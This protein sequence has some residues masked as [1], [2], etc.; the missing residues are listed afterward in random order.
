[1]KMK[2]MNYYYSQEKDYQHESPKE[3]RNQNQKNPR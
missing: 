3:T 1:M 2:M